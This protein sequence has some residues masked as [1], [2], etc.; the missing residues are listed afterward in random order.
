ME[1]ST[2][3]GIIS[4]L[5]FL[6]SAT[7]AA[8]NNVKKIDENMLSDEIAGCYVAHKY[9]KTDFF[10]SGEAEVYKKI[11]AQLSGEDNVNRIVNIADRKQSYVPFEGGSMLNSK[12]FARKYCTE[13][14]EKLTSLMAN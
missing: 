12:R 5:F 10:K 1:R 4:T 14:E 9:A 2:I 11:I 6:S 8:T 3:T 7:F 13:I